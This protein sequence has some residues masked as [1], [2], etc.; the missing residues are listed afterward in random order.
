MFRAILIEKAPNGVESV[1]LTELDEAELP[2]G[3]V[4]VRISH[5]TLNFKDA[6]A[7]TG[8]APV[9]RTFPIVPGIDFAGTVEHSTHQDFRVGDAVIGNGFGLG[10]K[11]WGGLAEKARVKAECLVP[12]PNGLSARDAMAI[13]TGGFTAM[14]SV[15]ALERHDVT[16]DKGP[17]LVTG[18]NGGVGSFAICL[19]AAL[20]YR[21]IA[22]TGRRNESEYLTR[23]GAS[24]IIDR[25][26]LSEPGRPLGKERW[27]GA[28]DSVGSHTL[29]NACASTML[30]GSV[31]ACGLA[32]GMDLPATVAPFILRGVNLLGIETS[33]R[34]RAERVATWQRL[35]TMAKS[36]WFDDI[37][38]DI[39]L[40]DAIAQSADL[41]AGRVR[42]RLVVNVSLDVA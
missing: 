2:Q 1:R 11:T 35:A 9:V 14:L 39:A 38:R 18:A 25:A 12:L 40:V 33:L 13:G 30:G 29:A 42:G 17:V 23:L 16:P 32:Q 8:K 37:A 22:S 4:T 19:L 21:V 15:K 6:L 10:E 26:E 31:A 7:I 41:L 27:A 36:T 20:G 24:E 28:I 5:S 34:P 3:D